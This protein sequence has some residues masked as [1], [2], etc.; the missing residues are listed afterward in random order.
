MTAKKKKQSRTDN[1]QETE[2]RLNINSHI[3]HMK[4]F[5]SR[6]CVQIK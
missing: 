6:Q 3:N 5:R 4:S 1:K 2:T